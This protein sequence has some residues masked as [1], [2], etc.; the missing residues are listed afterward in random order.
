MRLLGLTTAVLLCLFV[1]ACQNPIQRNV[2]QAVTRVELA[3][4][5]MLDRADRSAAISLARLD[6]SIEKASGEIQNSL[7][8]FKII[9]DEA[10]LNTSVEASKL[11]EELKQD[12]D[13]LEASVEVRIEQ[14]RASALEVVETSDAAVQARID[15]LFT[16]L[17]LFV[18]ET[19]TEIR[20]LI[21]PVI[22]L[23][24]LLKESVEGGQLQI[25]AI[26]EKIIELIDQVK[27]IFK[28]VHDALHKFQGEDP[29]TGL[30][31]PDSNPWAAILGGV[32]ALLSTLIIAWKRMDVQKNGDRWKPEELRELVKT[33]VEDY[34]KIGQF[35]D[36]VV[37][38]LERK[39]YVKVTPKEPS[40]GEEV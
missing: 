28:E 2:D 24:A 20:L 37:G 14:V 39:G 3:G 33:S 7:G 40:D 10:L 29:E 35:D 27:E 32:G 15:Q 6:R 13:E 1:G 18:T 23:A 17:R 21:G 12:L 11:R 25:A 38:L 36:E 30:A 16:E 9:Y 22:E 5:R 4:D 26:S 34:L 31:D 8:E 19:L